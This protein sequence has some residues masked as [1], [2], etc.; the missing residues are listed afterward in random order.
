MKLLTYRTAE[1]PRIAAL[2]DAG[3]ALDLARAADLGRADEGAFS[4]MLA[5]IEGGE[6][7]L[8]RA[9]TL[10]ATPVEEAVLPLSGLELMAPLPVPQQLRDCLAFERHLK[11]ALDQHARLAVADAPDPEQAY[12][13]LIA[14]GAFDI[15]P[16]WY[17]QPIYYKGNRFSVIGP[18]QDIIWPQYSERLDYELELGVVIGKTGKNITRERA[19]DH[20][21][22]FTI[23]N[24]MSARDAQFLELPG[25]LG[26]AKGKD[27]DT[28]N[29]MGPWIVTA[30]EFDPYGKTMIA[31]I[32]GEEWSRGDS[33]EIYHRYDRIVEHISAEE[34]L[35]A[36]E[37]IGSGTVGNGCGAEF[38]R[39]LRPG[40]VIELE[41]EGIGLLRNRVIKPD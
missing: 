14:S 5:L 24:D 39:W 25:R 27:F 34:T 2:I 22:G 16:V 3:R 23:Y 41:V 11:Q 20:I 15:A 26:P 6:A 10:L 7:A 31:R 4:S 9:R 13:E 12:R 37:V 29:V 38:N 18:E 30:D 33:G 35:Y 17:Q 21:F 19:F 32:N 8:D 1:G 36:G 28:G 40:D